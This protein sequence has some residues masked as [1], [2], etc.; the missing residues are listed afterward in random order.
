[1]IAQYD[2]NVYKQFAT[3]EVFQVFSQFVHQYSL[4]SKKK[5]NKQINKK[6]VKLEAHKQRNAKH[7]N[8]TITVNA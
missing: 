6:R 5:V 1:M 7:T 8:D 2:W 4:K 3:R